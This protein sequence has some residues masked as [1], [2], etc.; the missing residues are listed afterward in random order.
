MPSPYAAKLEQ[1]GRSLNLWRAELQLSLGLAV[2]GGWVWA[3]GLLDVWLR[4]ERPA[5]VTTWVVLLVLI[6]ATL[7]LVRSALRTGFTL[8]GVAATLEKAFPQLD[9]R[10]INYLQ[11]SR[12]PEGDPFKAAYVNAGVPGLD[13]L[14]LRQMR[15]RAKHRRNWTAAAG[16]MVLLLLPLFVFGQAWPVALWRTINP[17]TSIAPPSLTKIIKV[18]PGHSTVVQGEALSLNCTVKGF[19]GHEVRVEIEPTGSPKSVYS[20]GRVRAGDAQDFSYKLPKVTAGFRYRFRAGDAQDSA[21]F[22]I[23]TRPP[24]AFTSLSIVVVAPS[25]MRIPVRTLDAREGRLVLPAGAAVRLT[26]AV[27]VPL[28]GL[29]ADFGTGESVQFTMVEGNPT[30]WTASLLVSTGAAFTLRGEDT[31]AFALEEVIPYAVAPDNAAG[32]EIVSPTSRAVLPSGERPQIEFRIADDFGVSEVVMEAVKPDATRED[33]GTELKRWKVDGLREFRQVWRS[34][35]PPTGGGDVAYRVV[36]F[37]NRPRSPNQSFSANVVFNAPMAG[38]AAKQQEALEKEAKTNI[39]TVIELQK[40]NLADTQ[41]YKEALASTPEAKWK[42]AAEVQTKIRSIVHELLVN[43]LKPLGNLMPAVQKLYVNQMVLAVDALQSIPAAD[44]KKKAVLAGEAVVLETTILKHLSS[45]VTAQDEAKIERSVTGL[46]ALLESLLRNQGAALKQTLATLESKAKATTQLVDSQDKIGTEMANFLAACTQEA[47]QAAQTDAALAGTIERTVA[48]AGEL[49]I[50]NDMVIAAE[51]LEQNQ[52]V[53][54]V[55]LE[56]R[57]LSGLKVLQGMLDQIKMQ[58]E[59]EKRELLTEA[60]KQAKE[61]LEKIEALNEKIKEAMEQVKGQ[62]NKDDQKMDEMEEEYSELKANLK[63]ALLEIP[64]DL[65]IFTELNV[66]NDLVEDVFSVFQ[67]IEQQEGS[68][69]DGADKV[70]EVAFAKEDKLLAQMGE[71]KK[72]LDAMEMWLAEKPDALKVTTEA[73]DKAEMPESGIALAELAAAAQDLLGDLLEE[74]KKAA[75]EADDS[76]TNHAMPDITPGGE[77]AEGDISSFAAQGKSGN[78]TPDHKEQDGRSNVGRQGMAVGETAAGSGTIG[79]GDKDIE[80]RRT[81]EPMQSGKVDLA[82]EADTKATGG[83]KLGTGKADGKG[84]SGGAE[85]VDSMEA[86][87][88]EGMAALMA[89]QA[90]AL[91]AKASMKNVRVDSLQAAAHELRQ[92]SDA[93]AKG[94]IEQ[95]REFRKMAIS[96]LSRAATNLSAAPSGAMEAKGT[97]GAL[98]SMVESGPDQAPPKY[99]GKVAEYYKALNAA[100]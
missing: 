80:A 53:E 36:A 24:P 16:A 29:K 6:G 18:D 2:V 85:R 88:N 44:P 31:S 93:V 58:E 92:A 42:G 91:Y 23:G 13:K 11:L 62:K 98:G 8:E 84:M 78:Q 63:D 33:P 68:E 5:R 22:L 43:P 65:H 86:G 28:A 10:L 69:Q 82:G 74:D 70:Q 75:K 41:R 32:I 89:R 90:D 57:A 77:V 71:A 64:N 95:M 25:Y 51:R 3:L 49:K 50:R 34:E 96:S 27:N 7:W 87:S 59:A 79:E 97:A 55:P 30:T 94:N 9:N 38:E 1:A 67:E 15:D 54:A 52:C 40:R 46:S 48:K 19:E 12:N 81:E 99:R 37:D 45:A 20:I 47:A 56:E 39:E 61:K 72:R 73:H 26:A 100:L 21:W 4:M 14:D 17:F 83:G 60:V 76:A 66:A 35:A